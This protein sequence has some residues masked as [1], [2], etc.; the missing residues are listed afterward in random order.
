M[1]MD[2]TSKRPAAFGISPKLLLLLPTLVLGACAQ[3]HLAT[4]DK[5]HE[6]MAYARATV[7]YEKALAK[8]DDRAAALRAAEAYQRRNMLDRAA[9]WYGVADQMAPLQADTALQYGK[10][11]HGLQRT[12]DAIRQFDRVLA[13]EPDHALAIDLRRAAADLNVFYIDT[14]LFTVSGVDIPGIAGAFAAVPYK[15]GLVFAGEREAAPQKENPWTGLSYLDLYHTKADANGLWSAPQTLPGAVNGRFHDGPATFDAEGRTMYFTRSDYLK[16]RLNKDDKAVS[17]LKLFRAELGDDGQWGNI[18][19]FAYNGETFSTGH[20]ALSADGNTLYFISDRPGGLGGTDL[21]RS[22]RTDMGW[23]EPESLGAPVNTSGN[24]M[25]PTLQGDT[26]YFASN[27]HAGLGGLDIFRTWPEGDGWAVP[28]N[29]NYPIN[30][31]FDDFALVMLPGG[32]SGFLSSNR[33]GS[34]RIH[35]F[36]VHDPTLILI[37]QFRNE[38]NGQP[39]ADV[40]V[41]LKD[42]VTGEVFTMLTGPDGQYSFPLQKDR[43]YRVS[44]GKNG[45]FTE[46]RDLNTH[47]QRISRT[48]REDFDLKEVVIEKPILVPNIYYDLDRWDIRPEAAVE[49]DKLVRL[50][51]DNPELSFELS[52]HTDSRASDLYNLVLSEARAKSA[53]DYLVR[54]GVDQSRITA[55]GYGKRKLVNHCRDGV[56]C[57]E[58]E[59]QANRRTE[60]K[61]TRMEHRTP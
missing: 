50:F 20:A 9:H 60:F 42:L 4:A 16:F 13:S 31:P 10:V 49:L 40:E 43:A 3:H 23:S 41:N 61:V 47:G 37:G 12:P 21:Y 11:L 36:E 57:T 18:H 38:A 6:R 32:R 14:T 56:D 28:E 24:E 53:V 48:Y 29:L 1:H 59:H 8:V 30:T 22:T 15:G 5:A 17:H 35:R 52:S 33:S 44:G 58:E 34:D 54:Q 19:Q 26:L 55:K 25:F 7:N 46:S 45:M 51:N 2:H 39:M 27:G